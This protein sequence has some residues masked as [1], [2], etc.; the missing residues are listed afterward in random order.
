MLRFAFYYHHALAIIMYLPS[1]PPCA[2]VHACMCVLYICTCVHYF[3]F[4][5][6]RGAAHL[7]L[8]VSC[9]YLFHFK[10]TVRSTVF[11]YRYAPAIIISL[12]RAPAHI[13]IIL[14]FGAK[15]VRRQ[16]RPSMHSCL[17]ICFT[18]N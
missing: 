11:Y 10:L 6:V 7:C 2:H 9:A 8:P 12:L 17:Y 3:S 18:S 5:K 1:A 4:L 16:K 14:Y 13:H 15:Q